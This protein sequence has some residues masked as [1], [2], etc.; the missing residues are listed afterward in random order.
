MNAMP[1]L[2]LVSLLAACAQEPHARQPS[3]SSMVQP[4]PMKGRCWA[5][6]G[7][8]A[9][10]GIELPADSVKK[11]EALIASGEWSLLYAQT[12]GHWTCGA[13]QPLRQPERA[14]FWSVQCGDKHGS[15]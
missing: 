8:I 6:D 10:I 14:Q 13:L 5:V 7:P 2:I 11:V 1:P 12:A 4:I 9:G 15:K 3:S